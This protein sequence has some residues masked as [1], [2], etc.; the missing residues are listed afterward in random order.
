MINQIITYL[1]TKLSDIGY[2]NTVYCLA[3]KVKKGEDVYPAVYNSFGEYIR[4]ELDQK[5]S[6]CYWRKNGDVKFSDEKNETQASGLQYNTVIPLKLVC[7]I[8]K[9]SPY[10]DNYFADNLASDIIG[11]L[12]TTNAALKKSLLAKSVRITATK[13]STDARVISADEYDNVN[14]EA[15]YS[16]AY[17]SI[18]FEVE[19]KTNQ[20]C[21]S[22][23]CGSS[24]V[25]PTLGSVKILD[26]DGAVVANVACGGTYSVVVFSGIDGG[27]ST[28]VYTNSIVDP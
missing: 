17:F 1:N 24:H 4:L 8:N 23:F 22:T 12:T 7:F 6:A 13:Y 15:R 18:D 28:T 10:D 3:E 2:F 14:F 20:N 9:Q 19:V 21:Y 11:Y 16:H 26:Q 25:L 5:G 27:S